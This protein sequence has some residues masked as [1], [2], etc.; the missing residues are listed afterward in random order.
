MTLESADGKPIDIHGL[1]NT[2]ESCFLVVMTGGAEN[3][4][5]NALVLK[6][7]LGW[8]DIALIRA[9]SRY[10]RQVRLPFSQDYM[11]NTLRAHPALRGEAGRIV[12]RP[13]RSARRRRSTRANARRRLPPRSRKR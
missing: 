1:Q 9:I 13:L 7:G 5:Y 2:L 10:L 6:A 3:D 4:G 11:W 12:S 8:R